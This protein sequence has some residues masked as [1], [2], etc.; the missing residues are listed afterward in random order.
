MSNGSYQSIYKI[1]ELC[2]KHLSE[3]VEVDIYEYASCYLWYDR[4]LYNS[5]GEEIRHLRGDTIYLYER[6]ST[7]DTDLFHE[8]GHMIGRRKNLVGHAE[9]GF[10]G[11]WEREN[12][13]LVAQI[14]D[15]R[16]WSSYLNLFSLTHDNFRINAASEVWAEVFMLWHLQ[17]ALPEARLLDSAMAKLGR[18]PECIAIQNLASE[19]QLH[20]VPHLD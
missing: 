7:P 12:G 6:S 13:K 3:I 5:F 20:N 11:S 19:I 8:L 10:Q 14:S 4:P 1:R 17:P 18:E 15:R 2:Q 9:N 16:H